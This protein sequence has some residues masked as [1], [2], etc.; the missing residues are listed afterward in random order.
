MI[1]QGIKSRPSYEPLAIDPAGR[2]HLLVVDS[3]DA[4]PEAFAVGTDAGRY[5]EVWTI[6]GHSSAIPSPVEGTRV[7]GFRATRHLLIALRRRLAQEKMGFRVHVIGTEP[8]LWE[9]AGAAEEAGLGRE[10][11]ALFTVGSQARRLFCVHCRT[12]TD[13]VTTNVAECSGC[14]AHLFVRDHF[15]RRLNAFMGVQ[16]DAEVPGERPPVEELY[17]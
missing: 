8:F 16:V 6:E 14:G 12:I 1:D 17:L 7:H 11:Y 5:D 15:S 4:P 2:V 9:I 3:P 13:G 10:E